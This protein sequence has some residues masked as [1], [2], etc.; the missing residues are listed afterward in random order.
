MAAAEGRANVAAPADAPRE[1]SQPVSAEWEAQAAER[2]ARNARQLAPLVVPTG[3]PTV[4]LVPAELGVVQA[5]K[6]VQ[7]APGSEP[8]YPAGSE[9]ESPTRG[10]P[11]RGSMAGRSRAPLPVV[12]GFGEGPAEYYPLDGREVRIL[13]EK[14]LEEV[15]AQIQNDLRFHLAVT[16]P[17]LTATVTVRVEGEADDAGVTVEKRMAHE[18]TARDVAEA[19]ADSVVFVIRRQRREVDEAGESETPPDA[20]RDELGMA[21]PAKR[22][23][24][25]VLGQV[26]DVSW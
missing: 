20:L 2:A 11:G 21:R 26:A 15:R 17:R 19:H 23:L 24:G 16:Y 25:G 1:V 10:I 13:V 14:L 12:G 4:P 7:A 22:R 3:P 18:R 9:G 8:Y 6:A 5:P